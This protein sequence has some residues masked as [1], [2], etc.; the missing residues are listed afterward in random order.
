MIHILDKLLCNVTTT[1]GR[2]YTFTKNSEILKHINADNVGGYY[3]FRSKQKIN[4]NDEIDSVVPIDCTLSINPHLDKSASNEP[5]SK[6]LA[7]AFQDIP[8]N[9]FTNTAVTNYH[10][11]HNLSEIVL[12]NEVEYVNTALLH[13]CLQDQGAY[14]FLIKNAFFDIEKICCIPYR[15]IMSGVDREG[16]RSKW[17]QFL[18][19]ER[20]RFILEKT[21]IVNELTNKKNEQPMGAKKIELSFTISEIQKEIDKYKKINFK[22][23]T[24]NIL[25]ICDIFR[26][27][28]F[29]E[30]TSIDINPVNM[31]HHHA[32]QVCR[33]LIPDMFLTYYHVER[34]DADLIA[35]LTKLKQNCIIKH[36]DK[37]LRV[38]NSEISTLAIDSS[39]EIASLIKEITDIRT[40]I[41]NIETPQNFTS[42]TQAI[43]FWPPILNPM[44]EEFCLIK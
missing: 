1:E 35:A 20:S 32:Y 21:E 26:Y 41:E 34:N 38:L 3:D 13:V 11:L 8:S 24:D 22:K 28:P 9:E 36:K 5:F 12:N 10:G 44:P 14:N 27:Y 39:L 16:I 37:T 19:A 33:K 17:I 15:N 43:N 42:I 30:K 7:S 18:E 31:W 4:I 29:N 6:I 25:F 2:Q 40:L 23:E